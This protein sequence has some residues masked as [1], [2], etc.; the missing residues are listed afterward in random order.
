MQFGFSTAIAWMFWLASILIW[1]EIFFAPEP[2]SARYIFFPAVF[3]SLLPI[4]VPSP[5]LSSELSFLF[6]CHILVAMLA[7][8]S[9]ALAVAHGSI[10]MVHEASLRKLR[11]KKILSLKFWPMIFV[12]VLKKFVFQAHV[13]LFFFEVMRKVDRFSKFPPF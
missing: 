2:L 1:V 9:F 8:S 11:Q 7:Y 10:M 5:M 12:F 13:S 4:F 6:R 3:G